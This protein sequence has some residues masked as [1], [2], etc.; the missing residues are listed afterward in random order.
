[1]RSSQRNNRLQ[2]RQRRRELIRLRA[3]L[4]DFGG[5]AHRTGGDLAD[6]GRQHVH[7]CAG[8]VGERALDAV[9]GYEEEGCAWGGADDCASNAGVDAFESAG[10]EEAG[11]GL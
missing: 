4:D 9:V 3:L 2:R 7:A 11:A 5:D 6:T 10:C 8:R 1:M